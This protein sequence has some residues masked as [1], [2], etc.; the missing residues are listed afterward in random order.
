L[1]FEKVNRLVYSCRKCRLWQEATCAVP[2]EGSVNAEVMLVGQNP[3]SEEDKVGK[4]F[5]GRTGKYLDSVLEEIGLNRKDVFITNIVKHKTPKNR[6][7]RADEVAACL[8]YLIEQINIIKPKKIV[9][10]GKIA[11]RTPRGS[12][13]QYGETVHPQAALRFPKMGVKFKEQIR[14]QLKSKD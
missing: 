11:H 3:G 2:G 5:V 13:I 9:L 10:M 14:A 8:P 1:S 4:P 12:G 6:K 7:P